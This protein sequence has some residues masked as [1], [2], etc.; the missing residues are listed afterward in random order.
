M[1]PPPSPPQSF[2]VDVGP[3]RLI[4]GGGSLARLGEVATSLG[5]TR[6]LVVT[7]RG[8]SDAGHADRAVEI[9][10]GA[11]VVPE[12][13]AGTSS[14][15][16]THDVE[17]ALAVA[18]SH[19][20]D[21]LIGLGG[22]SAMDV[23]KGVNFVFTSGGTI[24]DYWG[25]G[26]ATKP[27]LPSIGVPTT[28]GTGSEAQSYALIGDPETHAKMACGDRKARF[29]AVI[30]DPDLTAT[31]PPKVAATAGLDA[32]GHAIES[33]VSLAANPV[34]RMF[35]REAFIAAEES[36]VPSLRPGASAD[37]R[38]RMLLAAYFAGA[39]IEASMLGAAHAA[40][41]PL[42]ARF[43]I[44]H[45]VAIALMLPHVIR[46]NASVA[47][48]GYIELVRASSLHQSRVGHPGAEA[49]AKRVESL[50]AAFALPARLRDC[51]V[52]EA[53]LSELATEAERQWTA[54]FN[55]RAVTAA[56]FTALYRD[57]F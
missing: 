55:P 17:R 16:T 37:L 50:R 41:N 28:A 26:K 21:L 5:G 8:V 9:L 32:L 34:S 3:N 4:A 22:G 44:A 40:A 25:F 29:H 30:L 36:L 45:G 42:S 56:D 27:M 39:A 57:A 20:A 11:G 14:D 24:A 51:D 1:S 38:L 43:G 47:G 7:D 46:F 13:F 15:P 49:L 19:R 48:D 54:G 2:T 35:A 6:A 18:K 53:S 52:T 12:V 31:T 10:V 23:A 33:Y